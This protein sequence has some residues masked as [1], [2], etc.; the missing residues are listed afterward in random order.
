MRTGQ[1][2]VRMHSPWRRRRVAVLGGLMAIVFVYGVYEWGRFDGGYNHFA[3]IQRKREFESRLDTLAQANEKLRGQV[4]TANVSRNVD[5]QSYSNVEKG[6][7]DL[8]AQVLRQREELTFYRGIVSPEDGIGGLRIQKFQVLSAGATGHFRLR[9]V[10]VQSMRQDSTVAGS[11]KLEIEGVRGGQPVHL[12][13]S[14]LHATTRA[15]G[16]MPFSF[17]Y[18]QDVQQD[19]ELPADFQPRA[20]NLEVHSPKFPAVRESFPWQVQAD[21]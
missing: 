10:L 4:A 6:L 21:G 15:D 3:E 8:Q 14:D 1:L 17:R 2:V 12:T 9:L 18:F 19:I 20:V 7:A 5:K 16:E 13:L 11:I